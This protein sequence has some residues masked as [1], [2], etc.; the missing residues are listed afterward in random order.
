ML[1]I[2]LC[3]CCNN[4]LINKRKKKLPQTD[5]PN[6]EC[7]KISLLKDASI[8]WLYKQRVKTLTEVIKV[9]ESLE[10]QWMDI[11]NIVKQAA[12]ET[13]GTK[14]RWHRKKGLWQWDEEISKVIADKRAA[15]K[16]YLLTKKNWIQ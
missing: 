8:Q 13:L 6:E 2:L 5:I 3:W 11:L 1:P 16:K 4:L 7:L 10:K 9:N 15:F 14:K 12:N